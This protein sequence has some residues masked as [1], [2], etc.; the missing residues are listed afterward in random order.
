MAD[1]KTSVLSDLELFNAMSPDEQAA[2]LTMV[3]DVQALGAKPTRAQA[4][5]VL[6]PSLEALF[7]DVYNA[8]KPELEAKF[9]EELV[10][11]HKAAGENK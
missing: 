7:G 2:Y 4:L 8:Y 9:G 5:A 6:V 3:S 11:A 1:D 10:A